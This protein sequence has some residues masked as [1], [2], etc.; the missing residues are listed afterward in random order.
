M[1]SVQQ[2]PQL[3]IPFPSGRPPRTDLSGKFSRPRTD[4]VWQLPQPSHLWPAELVG[5]VHPWTFRKTVG[6]QIVSQPKE[7]PS[8]PSHVWNVQKILNFSG[9]SNL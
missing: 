4:F 9:T 1:D 8:K 2:V 3:I 6:L 7:H 5:K